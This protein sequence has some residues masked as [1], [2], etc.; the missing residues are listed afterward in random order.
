MGQCH[1]SWLNNSVMPSEMLQMRSNGVFLLQK[2]LCW[3]RRA[4]AA[5]RVHLRRRRRPL[6]TFRAAWAPTVPLPIR[7]PPPMAAAELLL[8]QMPRRRP[9]AV[10]RCWL[11]LDSAAANM[12][13]T[14]AWM[15]CLRSGFCNFCEI[16]GLQLLSGCSSEGDHNLIKSVCD[17][18]MLC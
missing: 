11:L 13:P 1:A 15:G 7:W 17:T 5:L 6:V 2:P 10:A 8:R 12:Q 3:P 4:A 16:F 14:V 18:L 9:P